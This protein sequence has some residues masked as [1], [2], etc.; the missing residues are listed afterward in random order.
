MSN[1][2]PRYAA[3]FCAA[4]C[5]TTRAV[6]ALVGTFSLGDGGAP[7]A[8]AVAA[9]PAKPAELRGY[10]FSAMAKQQAR[11]PGGPDVARDL[12]VRV[13]AESLGIAADPVR[14]RS[15]CTTGSS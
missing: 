11:G 13:L 9:A 15:P 2:L 3:C 12:R 7:A 4:H 6:Y 10:V 8:P 14:T 5:T 1:V